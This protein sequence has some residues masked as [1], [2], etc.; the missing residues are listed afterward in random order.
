MDGKV[1]VK[2]S[3]KMVDTSKCFNLGHSWQGRFF[4][5]ITRPFSKKTSSGC[6]A[7]KSPHRAKPPGW[8][9]YSLVG[10]STILPD[11]FTITIPSLSQS[12]FYYSIYFYAFSIWIDPKDQKSIKYNQFSLFFLV[13]SAC[14][15]PHW[16]HSFLKCVLSA[17]F[18][19]RHIESNMEW[20]H[21]TGG[22]DNEDRR[23]VP[24]GLP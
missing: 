4:S 12:P 21:L 1:I 22:V 2:T 15:L 24:I 20:A 18:K 13:G 17:F 5:E 9:H 23:L 11:V 7:A 6:L 14:K 3:G 10:P 19:A 8:A 16:R